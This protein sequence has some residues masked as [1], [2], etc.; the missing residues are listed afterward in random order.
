MPDDTEQTQQPMPTDT[1]TVNVNSG[2]DTSQAPQTTS[3]DM[4][5][6]TVPEQPTN[7]QM[8]VAGQP[9]QSQDPNAGAGGVFEKVLQTLAGHPNQSGA[10]YDPDTGKLVATPVT[11]KAS[12]AGHIVA[13]AITGML[14]GMAA[15]PGPGH[16]AQA[17]NLAL[18]GGIQD[19][20]RQQSLLQA[21]Y[22]R[23]QQA[24]VQRYQVAHL[25]A[26]TALDTANAAA[27]GIETLQKGKAMN[28]DA[29]Q[30]LAASGAIET[31]ASGNPVTMTQS[32]ILAK[33]KSGELNAGDVIGMQYGG[34]L[35]DGKPAALYVVNKDPNAPVKISQDQYDRWTSQGVNVPKEVVGQS[36]P[37]K[38]FS[39]YTNQALVHQTSDAALAT[40]RHDAGSNKDLL[41]KLP[42][43]VDPTTPG[44]ATA[45]RTFQQ[46]LR[47]TKGDVYSA[48]EAT[49]QKNP[50]SGQILLDAF[51]GKDTIGDIANQHSSDVK[52]AQAS[53]EEDARQKASLPYKEADQTF[54]AK[55]R[56]QDRQFQMSLQFQNQ[57]AQKQLSMNL[58]NNK[59]ARDKTEASVLK[60]YS[61]KMGDIEQT[62]Q[63]IA[64]VDTNPVAARAV[65]FKMIGVA[66][67]TGSHRVLPAEIDAFRYPGNIAQRSVEKFN[68]FLLGKP[69]TKEAAQA[70][71]A[72]VDGQQQAAQNNLRRGVQN[73]N[74]LYGTNIDSERIL[75]AGQTQSPAPPRP[76]GVPANTVWNGQANSGRGMWVPVQQ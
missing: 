38:S 18:E 6:A 19:R 63:A 11:S 29:V 49:Y 12:L 40:L 50:Q 59:D 60:P 33:V 72:F 34:T 55:Q 37:A 66:Q 20:Q 69:W 70:A 67:P 15:P 31:D 57:E 1:Q 74:G 61:D 24:Q 56:Q 73:I 39:A 65:V 23:Q 5:S 62:R 58:E 45:L 26:Q 47:G 51:G 48:L 36:I 2:P 32:D 76:A 7:G 3:P 4:S 9:A 22:E 16:V 44:M 17:G 30:Q 10:H 13:A 14:R 27:A 75:N 54:E 52:S 35:I 8:Y 43:S 64:Q 68:D 46:A 42:A 25:N 71:S 53:E 41:A 21:D 28:D